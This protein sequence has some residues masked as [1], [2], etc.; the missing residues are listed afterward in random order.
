[1]V[2]LLAMQKWVNHSRLTK[3]QA[4]RLCSNRAYFVELFKVLPYVRPTESWMQL[5]H[6]QKN[7]GIKSAWINETLVKPLSPMQ[8]SRIAHSKRPID[9]WICNEEVVHHSYEWYTQQAFNF[10]SLVLQPMQ[11]PY[12]YTEFVP[13][14]HFKELVIRQVAKTSALSSFLT[15]DEYN[16]LAILQ[17]I[18]V[19]HSDF[20]HTLSDMRCDQPCTLQRMVQGYAAGAD[21]C[22]DLNAQLRFVKEHPVFINQMYSLVW[23]CQ[24]HPYMNTKLMRGEYTNEYF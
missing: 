22:G 24:C 14:M 5:V 17:S 20:M 1:M 9:A 4:N 18:E 2:R 19:C 21:K 13:T 12:Y 6:A 15:D 23:A 3:E 7:A 10:W 8:F 16:E 11:L